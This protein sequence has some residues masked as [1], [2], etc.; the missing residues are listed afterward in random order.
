[1]THGRHTG[2]T[3]RE[4]RRVRTPETAHHVS[5]SQ[6][7]R[8]MTKSQKRRRGLPGTE[9]KVEGGAWAMKGDRGTVVVERPGREEAWPEVPDALHYF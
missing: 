8:E 6:N 7:I 1:M 5:H 3:A 4:S 2:G 9:E